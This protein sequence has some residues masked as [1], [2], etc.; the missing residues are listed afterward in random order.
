[1]EMTIFF[2]VV[3]LFIFGVFASVAVGLHPLIV[4]AFV[5]C[6]VAGIYMGVIICDKFLSW[7]KRRRQKSHD[8][9]LRDE[10]LR[11]AINQVVPSLYKMAEKT[12]KDEIA[13]Y[14]GDKS[15]LESICKDDKT[16]V[17]DQLA[18]QY[19]ALKIR[20][21]ARHEQNT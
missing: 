18:N 10:A 9:V 7:S 21:R 20:I 14:S 13:S 11:H 17:R 3:I 6:I 8:E 15:S 16:T 19:S 4:P 12:I 5:V 2:A 1:M